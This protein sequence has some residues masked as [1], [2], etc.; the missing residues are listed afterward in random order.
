MRGCHVTARL[1]AGV[2]ARVARGVMLGLGACLLLAGMGRL[3][4]PAYAQAQ[5]S[6]PKIGVVDFQRVIERS[7]AGK[8]AFE[9]LK[10]IFNDKQQIIQT[11]QEALQKLRDELER[12]GA[13]MAAA[14]RREREETFQKEGRELRRLV[15]DARDDMRRE[16]NDTNQRLAR[17]IMQISRGLGERLGF[18]IIL[19]A[20]DGIVYFTKAIDLTEQVIGAYDRMKEEA[21]NKP[22]QKP[23]APETKSKRG[24]K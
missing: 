11:R 22:P 12:R 17:E 4:M 10:A 14:V 1:V 3:S 16:E 9:Q 20:K 18:T 6:A 7:I 13:L 8:Q 15:T 2:R 24:Q 19:E 23:A 5:S 21:A